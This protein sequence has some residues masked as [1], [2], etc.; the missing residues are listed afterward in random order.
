MNTWIFRLLWAGL[1]SLA[2]LLGFVSSWLWTCSYEQF[3]QQVLQWVNKS[4]WLPYFQ[5]KVFPPQRFLPTQ[6]LLTVLTLSYSIALY[7]FRA[8]V[9][10]WSQDI[11][12]LIQ[13][14]TGFF[15]RQWQ[16]DLLWERRIYLS[17]LALA[18]LYGALQLWR[19][20]LQY[21]EAWT[22]NHFVHKGWF[23]SAISPNNNHILYTLLAS[24][25]NYLPL[26]AKYSLR[27]P[28]YLGGLSL[29]WLSYYW[30]RL[31]WGR[32]WALLCLAW[33][34]FSPAVVLYS[35]YARAY[36]FQ[37]LFTMLGIGIAAKII[38][39]PKPPRSYWQ[40]LGLSLILGLYSV[41]THAYVWLCLSLVLLGL[42]GYKKR[43]LRPFFKLQSLSIGISLLL[44]LPLVLTNGLNTLLT[45]ATTAA[46][47]GDAFWA[48][49]DKVADWLLVGGGRFTP[50]YWFWL[51]HCLLVLFHYYYYNKNKP[52]KT[53]HIPL[54]IFPFLIAFLS[55]PTLLHLTTGTQPPYRVWCFLAPVL[56][57]TW[58]CWE[59]HRQPSFKLIL[60][61]I[62]LVIAY[63]AWRM[64][65]HYALQ[66]SAQ[67]DKSAKTLAQT[68]LDQ[69]IQQC[70]LFPHYDKPLLECYYLRAGQQL[71]VYMAAPNSQHHAPLQSQQYESILWDK[72]DYPYSLAEKEWVETQYPEIL[73][74]DERLVLRQ[75]LPKK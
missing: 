22:Y 42:L 4:D 36:I 55:L 3:A 73:Y 58:P 59:L 10:H 54:A 68:M 64:E 63:N 33:L 6:C 27:L 23:V 70:Y 12:Q 53:D 41:P 57:F 20:E 1:L 35:L 66:W 51:L 52:T 7:R 67:L 48:Y 38:A 28:V 19:Y 25:S 40:A 2:L 60:F 13:L 32:Q 49:Q 26:E 61:L 72:E 17:L 47:R 30:L 34:A 50:V 21:D 46:P 16:Q 9:Q 44:Y 15:K 69:Q 43:S 18:A 14:V 71:E 29:L 39:T 75:A 65:Q 74:E 11:V 37:I 8:T 5:S 62:P 24:W 56:A 31:F 45:A